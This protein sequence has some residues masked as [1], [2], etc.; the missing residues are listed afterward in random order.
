MPSKRFSCLPT[1]H[2]EAFATSAS[3]IFS[4][5]LLKEASGYRETIDDDNGKQHFAR[6]SRFARA[7][8]FSTFCY[9]SP[10]ISTM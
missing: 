7:S 10:S 2:A 4:M 6:F 5:S 1:L 9:R 3:Y 8:S